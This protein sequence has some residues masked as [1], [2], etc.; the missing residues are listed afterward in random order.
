VRKGWT[1]GG[2][3]VLILVLAGVGAAAVERVY[4][5]RQF[6]RLLAAGEQALATGDT[7]TAIE[8]LSGALALRPESMVAYLRRGE[9]YRDQKRFDEADRD[10]RRAI[11]LTPEA[12]QAFVALGDLEELKG[13]PAVAADW[14][15]QAAERL[16]GEDASLL[17]RLAL[18]QF[19]AGSP[20]LAL[21]PLKAAVAKKESSADARYLLGLV[22]RDLGNLDSAIDALESAIAIQPSLVAAREELADAYRS[23]G[24]PVEEMAA[25]QALAV[26]DNQTGRQIAIAEAEVR[27]GQ[28]DAALGTLSRIPAASSTEARVQLAIGRVYLARAERSRD[29]DGRSAAKALEVLERA[30]GASAPRSEGLALYGR[31][32]FVSGRCLESEQ[33]LREAI[34]TSPVNREAFLFL[35][36]AAEQCGHDLIARDAL[37]N[38]DVLEGDTAP[39]EV[40][41]RRASRIGELSLRAGDIRGAVLYLSRAVDAGHAPA[42][43]LGLLADARWQTGDAETARALLERALALSP[44]DPALLRLSRVIR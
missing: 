26:V 3:V 29:P 30:L 34:S 2:G 33:A 17:Y 1:I 20:G 21:A 37:V 11:Q 12:P 15:A 40:R 6:R 4:S 27:H 32:L 43:T 5:D 16:K 36:D 8:S 39:A 44:R 25:L 14:F 31:A 41:F 24:R 23:A 7:Y 18:A 35:A 42:S 13:N 9:A 22:Y 38:F 19:K 10:W 28:L